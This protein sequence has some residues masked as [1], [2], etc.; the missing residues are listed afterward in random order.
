MLDF[1]VVAE[2]TK[3]NARACVLRTPHGPVET[4]V[5]MPVG[6]LGTVKSMSPEELTAAGARIILGNTYH[7]YL[8]PGCEV[9]DRFSGLHGFM[10]WHGPILTDSGGFQIF[11]L[12]K[13]LKFLLGN[14][15][16]FVWSFFFGL[17]LASAIIVYRKI[18]NHTLINIVAIITGTVVMF[19]VTMFAPTESSEAYW[20]IFISGAIAVCAMILPGI[21]GAFILLILGKY[22]FIL[23]SVS[24]FDLP[25]LIVFGFGVI[26][27]LVSFSNLLSWLLARYRDVTI[28]VLTGFLIGSL[29]KVWPWKETITSRISSHGDMVPLIQKNILPGDYDVLYGVEHGLVPALLF[30]L[31]GMALVLILERFSKPP[32]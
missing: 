30:M 24:T 20:F 22:Q 5:F 4:P 3:T 1:N 23:D 26:M 11:S 6:T 25:V 18:S 9:I 27:G 16:I 28:S 21:S 31:I 8:R 17:I 19:I 2:S 32:E 12:A 13:L 15:P 29:N 7:L 10:N 14:Y